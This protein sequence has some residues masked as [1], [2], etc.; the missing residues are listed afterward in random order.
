M[1]VPCPVHAAAAILAAAV[2][3]AA[4]T[5]S[6]AQRT[7]FPS[8]DNTL[9]QDAA[10]SLS[11]GSGPDLFVGLTHAMSIRRALVRFDVAA[12]V[13]A[14]AH[15]DSVWLVMTLT[16]TTA[17]NP[18]TVTLHRVQASW[19]EGTSNS[20]GG[21]LGGGGGAPATPGDATWLHRS[22]A[23][24]NWTAPGG[25]YA[26]AVSGQAV[27]GNATTVGEHFTW[28]SSAGMVADVQAWLDTP[29]SNFG[30]LLHGDE[31]AGLGVQTSRRFASREAE[32]EAIRPQLRIIFSG[33]GVEP[34]TWSRVKSL[35]R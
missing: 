8:L 23:T 25:D 33:V 34:H 20:G 4:A 13:P 11:N 3:G 31:A 9:I 12:A 35:F 27:I 26:A 2:Q 17:S 6:A 21:Q 14:G 5:A 22:F 29:A 18:A 1:R 30:W 32:A 7:L 15:V 16:R 19:G 10:G 28:G 24:L